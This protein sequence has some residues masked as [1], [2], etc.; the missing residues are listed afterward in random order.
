MVKKI[1][2]NGEKN[3]CRYFRAFASL[4]R[5]SFPD[6]SLLKSFS[7]TSF[8]LLV[9]LMDTG[10][11]SEASSLW[12]SEG[13]GLLSW[14]GTSSGLITAWGIFK[15]TALSSAF[16]CSISIVCSLSSFCTFGGVVTVSEL[17]SL[18]LWRKRVR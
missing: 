6:S 7:T 13:S 5:C 12:L 3:N 15:L 1:I 18:I 9:P 2:E 8:Q 10:F 4:F 17:L 14:G 16:L 11:V